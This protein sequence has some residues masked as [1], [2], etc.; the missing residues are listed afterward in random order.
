MGDTWVINLQHYLDKR[1]QIPPTLPGPARRLAGYFGSIAYQATKPLEVEGVEE[2]PG[3]RCR[4][5]PQR[6]ACPGE[7][8]AWIDPQTDVIRWTC[9]WCGDNGYISGWQGTVWDATAV[10]GTPRH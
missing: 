8:A 9:T 4:R 6:R 1:G 7:I 3:V 10:S 2:A 5:R